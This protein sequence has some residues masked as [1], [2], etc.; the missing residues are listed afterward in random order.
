M[1]PD[2]AEQMT[3]TR[4]LPRRAFRGGASLAAGLAVLLVVGCAGWV[5]NAEVVLQTAPAGYDAAMT[6]A[7]QNRAKLSHETLA[8][9]E[10]VRVQFPPAYRAFD[11]ALAAYIKS[12]SKDPAD[13]QPLLDEVNRLIAQL[14]ALCVL[15][16]GPNL[17][18]EK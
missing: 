13:V 10:A 8:K 14:Q 9:F 18:A 3:S 12:G 16:G 4:A 1:A 7:G 6:F 15:N 17:G 5:K 11:S 2:E